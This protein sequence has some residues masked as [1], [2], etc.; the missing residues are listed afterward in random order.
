VH[1]SQKFSAPPSG[2]TKA[3]L[4]KLGRF[5]NDTNLVY[6]QDEYGGTRTSHAAGERA[7][8]FN[9]CFFF[10]FLLERGLPG[11]HPILKLKILEEDNVSYK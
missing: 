5:K 2:V 1:F 6:Q 9:V 3:D 10:D 7:K 11:G 4:E 8:N